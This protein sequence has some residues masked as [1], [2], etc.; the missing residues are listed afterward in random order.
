MI[1]IVIDSLVGLLNGLISGT[2]AFFVVY[3]F[4]KH[5]CIYDQQQIIYSKSTDKAPFKEKG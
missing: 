1:E 2:L 4:S 5:Y 3:M